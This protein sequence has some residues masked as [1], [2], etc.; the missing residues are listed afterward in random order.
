MDFKST[1]PIYQQIADYVC[2]KVVGR[3]WSEDERIPSARD[4]GVMLQVNPN[5]VIR[6]FDKLQGE[7]I[8]SNRRGVGYFVE[9][10][11]LERILDSRRR[12][13]TDRTLPEIFASMRQ[14][15]VPFDEVASQWQQYEKTNKG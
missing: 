8:V 2:D 10:G 5:T 1:L 4:M 7:G 14:L 9:S 3:E 11:A 6:A 13:F 12:D 15:G